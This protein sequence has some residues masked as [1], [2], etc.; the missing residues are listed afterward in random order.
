MR[1]RPIVIVAFDGVQILDVTGP[2]EVFAIANRFVNATQAPYAERGS[3]RHIQSWIAGHLTHDLSVAALAAEAGMS[4][5]NFSRVFGKEVGVTPA[6]YVEAARIE[7]AKRLLETTAAGAGEIAHASG[8][9]SI[10]TLHRSFKKRVGVTPGG[11]RYR[12]HPPGASSRRR[13]SAGA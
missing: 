6:D 8:F 9:G 11:F 2:G 10:E 1:V 5:R 12:F 4:V 13:T 7:A 3:V